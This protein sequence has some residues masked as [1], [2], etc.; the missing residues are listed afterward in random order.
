[1]GTPEVQS[2]VT[3]LSE[4]VHCRALQIQLFNKD[5]GILPQI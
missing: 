3:F 4:E 1:M 5:E 2:I